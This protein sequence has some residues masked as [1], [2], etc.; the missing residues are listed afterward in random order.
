MT[1]KDF[2]A[3]HQRCAL[4]FSGGADSAYLLAASRALGADVRPYFVRTAFQPAFEL[5]DARRLAHEL[6][7][8]LGIIE[9]DIL[10]VPGVRENPRNRCYFCK[11]AI[12]SAICSRAEADG[13]GCVID[14]TNASD[15]IA[16]RPGWRAIR[17]LGVLS[18]LR[19]CGITKP[20]LRRLSAE[21]GLFTAEKPAYACL[22]TRVPAG[23]EIAEGDLQ[24]IERAESALAALGYSDFRVRLTPEGSAR[25]E[26]PEAQ[27]VRAAEGRGEILS[28]L[29]GDFPRVTLDL[30]GR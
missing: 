17:E 9:Y 3:A 22:A 27:L 4:G 23:M 30:K 15:D 26:L 10:A 24:R 18:P 7:V 28:R 29:A 12:F 21:L 20:E 1:L 14:G 19:E 2:F 16:D 25:L 11:K 8:E 6:G 13:L 5:D